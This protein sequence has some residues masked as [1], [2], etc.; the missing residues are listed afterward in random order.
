MADAR[1]EK[2]RYGQHYTPEHVARLLAAFAVKSEGARVLDPSCGD[3][4]LLRAAIHTKKQISANRLRSESV[5]DLD[6]AL[7]GETVGVERSPEAAQLA[8][9][10]GARIIAADFFDVTPGEIYRGIGVSA[11]F[12]AIIGNPPYIRQELMGDSDKERI[13]LRLQTPSPFEHTGDSL[14]M[15]QW[16]KR[17]DIYVYFF[18]HAARFLRPGGRIA[19]LT[20]SNWLDVGYGAQ[21]R[22]FLLMNFRVIA[23][24][25]SS[26]ES[27]F[28]DAS[29]NTTITVLERE[30]NAGVRNRNATRF[31][32]LT[33]PLSEIFAQFGPIDER[34]AIAFAHEIENT[35]ASITTPFHRVRVVPRKNLAGDAAHGNADKV[36]IDTWGRYLRA[37][38][39]FFTILE[40]G[41]GL[42]ELSQIADVRFGV[43]TGA[44]DFFYLR[45]EESATAPA[46]SSLKP[47]DQM[48][49]LRRGLTTGA[50]EFFYLTA[51]AE[52]EAAGL[53]DTTVT[54]VKD[55][56][57]ITHLIEARFLSPIVF[58]LKE[59][60]GIYLSGE[61]TRKLVF[62]CN[63]DSDN[64]E[65]THALEYIRQGE[66]SEVHKRSTCASRRPWYSVARG[67]APAP[68]ILPSK[69]GA[70]WLVAINRAGV[71]E[72]KK[73]YGVFPAPGVSINV[74]AALLNSTWARCCL[75]MTC[76]QLTGAQAIADIDV[77]VAERM[78]L[79]APRLSP[80][81]L[82]SGLE[83]A[84]AEL[85]RRPIASL[86][87]ETERPDR[88]RLDDLVLQAIG[89]NSKPERERVMDELYSTVINLVRRRLSK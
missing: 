21:L 75:E 27:F 84:L 46:D 71:L 74:L 68:L 10:C 29:I 77:A 32:Y 64:L 39:V 47:L 9:E 60:P 51:S 45:A 25:E 1:D 33:S 11:D 88:R 66:R 8:A 56:A 54:K 58:S 15:P 36:R 6:N 70:R 18:A 14:T 38:G 24:L 83:A 76:R 7:A 61:R 82:A 5:C 34:E 30:P 40:R 19:F 17:S 26:V 52:E 62:D 43:K 3:G 41:S 23:I 55:A 86:F 57:G 79:R 28:A 13:A 80:S 67:R 53:N 31:V 87:E 85:G 72:D 44:N 2:H 42:T 63:K 50:N 48:A 89:F 78:L 59:M 22:E 35:K 73:Q 12:D 4:R 49:S 65:G 69:I 81:E 20:S 37:D 16:S